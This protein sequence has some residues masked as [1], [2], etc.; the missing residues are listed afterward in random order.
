VSI[1]SLGGRR[2]GRGA[3]QRQQELRPSGLA[4]T[5]LTDDL[6][7]VERTRIEDVQVSSN[8]CKALFNGGSTGRPYIYDHHRKSQWLAQARSG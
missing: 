5:L 7:I 4:A 3:G 6:L 1:E 8:Y 2:Q